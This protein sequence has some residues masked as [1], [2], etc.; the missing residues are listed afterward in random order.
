MNVCTVFA[1]GAVGTT[2]ITLESRSPLGT[3][4]C[5]VDDTEVTGVTG[6]RLAADNK[7]VLFGATNEFWE[8]PVAA[9]VRASTTFGVAEAAVLVGKLGSESA[10]FDLVASDIVVF[11]GGGGGGRFGAQRTFV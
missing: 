2:G 3:A 1:V 9:T 10:I 8:S 6:P 7:D 5:T 4:N 11:I